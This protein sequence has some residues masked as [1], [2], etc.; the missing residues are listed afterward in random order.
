[1]NDVDVIIATGGTGLTGRYTTPE[2][3]DEIKD[4]KIP[5]LENYLG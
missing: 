4:K 5:G 1:M 3:L 2:A